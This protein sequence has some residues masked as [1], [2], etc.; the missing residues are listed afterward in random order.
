MCGRRLLLALAFLTAASCQAPAPSASSG[1]PEVKGRVDDSDGQ[2]LAHVSVKFY[3][4]DEKNKGTSLICLTQSDGTFTGRCAPGRYKVTVWAAPA[5]APKFPEKDKG[6]A[7]PPPA[8]TPP[9]GVPE[10]YGSFKD[11]PW[12]VDVPAGGK[13]GIVLKVEAE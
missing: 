3:P 9:P 11:T 5:P 10:R 6:K 2:P 8:P 4:L 1:P 7:A 13:T 12:E